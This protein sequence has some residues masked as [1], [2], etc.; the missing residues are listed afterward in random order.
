[1]KNSYPELLEPGVSFFLIAEMGVKGSTVLFNFANFAGV[2][3]IVSEA[4]FLFFAEFEICKRCLGTGGFCILFALWGRSKITLTKCRTFFD[5][6]N[7]VK[8]FLTIFLF[9]ILHAQ[10]RYTPLIAGSVHNYQ[11]G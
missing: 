3:G 1:M 5:P 2:G 11:I 8:I 9:Q 4:N 6:S 7:L 10:N